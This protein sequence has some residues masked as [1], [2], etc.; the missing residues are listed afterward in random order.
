MA[1]IRDTQR[2]AAQQSSSVSWR[3]AGAQFYPGGAYGTLQDL[4]HRGRG[5][6]GY[7]PSDAR[8]QEIICERLT[9]D[10]FVDASDI[11]IDVNNGEVT[12]QGSV[13]V[14]RQKYAIEDVI[15]DVAGVS[16][17]HNYVRVAS[18]DLDERMSGM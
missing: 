6:K 12:V 14:R 5:P 8:L 7:R 13:E 11:T 10:P 3:A 18:A 9:E 16:E 1:S 2:D 17:I 4:S 15:A